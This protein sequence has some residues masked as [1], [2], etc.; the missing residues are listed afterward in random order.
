[1]QSVFRS[2]PRQNIDRSSPDVASRRGGLK[3]L[4]IM[5]SS[6]LFDE[7]QLLPHSVLEPPP[8]LLCSRRILAC[9]GVSPLRRDCHVRHSKPTGDRAITKNDL[10]AVI[11]VSIEFNSVRA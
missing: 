4:C 2:P 6:T 9:T 10:R 7:A 3:T 8:Q 1:M 11:G 5:W